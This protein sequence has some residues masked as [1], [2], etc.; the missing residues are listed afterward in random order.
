MTYIRRN[1]HWKQRF[2]E[3][4]DFVWRR[5]VKFGG[6]VFH[7]G[8]P[9][10][11]ALFGGD[12]RLRRVKLLRFWHSHAIELANF[13]GRDAATGEVVNSEVPRVVARVGPWYTVAHRGQVHRALGKKKLA[14]LMEEL[15]NAAA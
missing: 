13:E 5:T 7:A 12:A 4:A 8:D 1:R 6:Q 3:D 11:K 2:N 9:V 14:S 10:D 15:T